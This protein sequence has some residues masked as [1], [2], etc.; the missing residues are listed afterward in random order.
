MALKCLALGHSPPPLLPPRN[1]EDPVWLESR[2]R[3]LR[4]TLPLSHTGSIWSKLK[5]FVDAKLKVPEIM[6]FAHDGIQN[7]VE[8][9]ENAGYKHFLLFPHFLFLSQGH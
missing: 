4:V 5:V 3:G 1:P 9:G 8:N 7:I 6:K 2:N